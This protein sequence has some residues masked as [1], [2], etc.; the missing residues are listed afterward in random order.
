MLLVGLLAVAVFAIQG[1]IASNVYLDMVTKSMTSRVRAA[2]ATVTEAG[3]T[4]ALTRLRG[5]L[6]P[7]G[8]ATFSFFLNFGAMPANGS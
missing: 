4:E 6:G 1:A 2:A 5:C 8:A 7:R 3:Y